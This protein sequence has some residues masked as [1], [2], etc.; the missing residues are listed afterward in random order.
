MHIYP[1]LT[2]APEPHRASAPDLAALIAAELAALM[3]A[4]CSVRITPIY[5]LESVLEFTAKTQRPWRIE[6]K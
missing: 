1:A 5:H 6:Q 3:I 2:P 4:G